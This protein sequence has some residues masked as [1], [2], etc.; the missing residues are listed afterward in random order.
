VNHFA[1]ACVALLLFAASAVPVSAQAAEVACAVP[2]ES[3]KIGEIALDLSRLLVGDVCSALVPKLEELEPSE[4][5]QAWSDAIE[6]FDDAL[7]GAV[8][9]WSCASSTDEFCTVVSGLHLRVALVQ[10]GL[11]N[12]RD[13]ARVRVPNVLMQMDFS[14]RELLVGTH[15]GAVEPL[16]LCRAVAADTSMLAPGDSQV[17]ARLQSQV[18]E[19]D[20]PRRVKAIADLL[21]GMV[22]MEAA[23]GWLNTPAAGDAARAQRSRADRWQNYMTG[24]DASE[25]LWPWELFVNGLVHDWDDRDPPDSY[26][27]L[28]RPQ[29][30]LEFYQS[31]GAEATLTGLVELA[32]WNRV[33]YA[34]DDSRDDVWGVSFVLGYGMNEETE[35]LGYGIQLKRLPRAFGYRGLGSEIDIAVLYRED[36]DKVSVVF[37]KSLQ[38]FFTKRPCEYLGSCD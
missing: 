25:T 38:S 16:Q 37:S 9:E 8:E 28:L 26:F 12:L 36:D 19:A 2:A 30:G 35:E 32:G 5:V 6:A 33:E 20:C 34:D 31:D 14:Q 15:Q 10:Q 7:D 23:V 21:P 24:D 22:A 1:S 3:R 29:V 18:C 11:A 17:C 4:E 13:N 27:S